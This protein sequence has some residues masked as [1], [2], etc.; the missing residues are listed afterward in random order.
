MDTDIFLGAP[1]GP[2]TMGEVLFWYDC[3]RSFLAQ[4]AKGSQY[5]VHQIDE[6]IDANHWDWLVVPLDADG[7]RLLQDANADSFLQAIKTVTSP[8]CWSIRADFAELACL[9][10]QWLTSGQRPETLL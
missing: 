8:G 3:P 6:D 10:H 9:S 4:D 1:F 2:L 7:L 5:F